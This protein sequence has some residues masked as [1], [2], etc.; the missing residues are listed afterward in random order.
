MERSASLPFVAVPV[1][2]KPYWSTAGNGKTSAGPITGNDPTL[3]NQ[4]AT[5]GFQQGWIQHLVSTFGEYGFVGARPP[6]YIAS[7]SNR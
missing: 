3:A 1:A 6:R 7:G 4:P 5:P 2:S